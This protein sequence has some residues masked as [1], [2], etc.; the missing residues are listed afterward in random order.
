L[1]GE[2]GVLTAVISSA[3]DDVRRL[4]DGIERAFVAAVPARIARPRASE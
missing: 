1:T 3:G 2:V 4:G